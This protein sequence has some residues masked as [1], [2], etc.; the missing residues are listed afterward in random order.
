MINT[1]RPAAALIVLLLLACSAGFARTSATDGPLPTVASKTRSM[2]RYEGLFTRWKEVYRRT[3]AV[4][5]DGLL[6]PLWRAPGT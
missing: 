5:D 6:A 1:T 2:E 3:K 4:A